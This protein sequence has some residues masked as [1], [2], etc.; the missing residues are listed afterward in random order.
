SGPPVGWALTAHWPRLVSSP[1]CPV[2]AGVITAPPRAST[3]A[4]TL[5]V[6][7]TVY[8]LEILP[9]AFGLCATDDFGS[10]YFH[11]GLISSEANSRASRQRALVFFHVE[12]A[13]VG[14]CPMSWARAIALESDRTSICWNATCTEAS[15]Q[16][17]GDWCARLSGPVSRATGA[18]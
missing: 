16:L 18:H 17:P 10:L 1:G 3:D 4:G 11:P 9:P 15:R 13:L 6:K 14:L 8:Q 2:G 12:N 7:L 5:A